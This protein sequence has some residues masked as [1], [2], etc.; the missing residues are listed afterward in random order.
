M[1]KEDFEYITSERF[2]H[3]SLLGQAENI[4]DKIWTFWR[5]G[6]R[7]PAVA[8]SW[9]GEIIQDDKGRPINDRVTL[10]VKETTMSTKVLHQLAVRTKAYGLLVV[11]DTEDGFIAKF[12]T[13]HGSRIWVRPAVRIG[14]RKILGKTQVTN[15][16][17]AL[18]LLW[19]PS[20]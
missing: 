7:L 16:A 11:E 3:D 4:L 8:V 1:N 6:E 20:S 17:T 19:K 15:D 14:D 2:I 9:P 10:R 13:K 18:G 12:E 5:A